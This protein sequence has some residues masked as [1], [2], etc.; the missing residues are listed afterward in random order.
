MKTTEFPTSFTFAFNNITMSVIK[1]G[2]SFDVYHL[3]SLW[4]NFHWEDGGNY[5]AFTPERGMF[6]DAYFLEILC[7]IGKN[8]EHFYRLF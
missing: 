1:K 7:Y 3:D 4:G 8:A 2:D 5:M 6:F